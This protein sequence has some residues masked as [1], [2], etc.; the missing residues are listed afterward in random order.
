MLTI[1]GHTDIPEGTT[2]MVTAV[3][4]PYLGGDLTVA[5]DLDD[6]GTF[7]TTLFDAQAIDGAFTQP[8]RV[9]LRDGTTILAEI[10]ETLIVTN[11]PPQILDMQIERPVGVVGTY[12]GGNATFAD[13]PGD[14]VAAAWDWGDG[15]VDSAGI[16]DDRVV[17]ST[18]MYT[19]AGTYTA[20]LTLTDDAG[21]QAQQAI[22]VKVVEPLIVTFTG[23]TTLP[24]GSTATLGYIASR[25]AEVTLEDW[26]GDGDG[27]FETP[28]PTFLLDANQRDGPSSFPV[29]VR[30]VTFEDVAAI[31]TVMI[32][33]TNVPLTVGAVTASGTPSAGQL[34]TYQARISDPGVNDTFTAQW[35]WGDGTTRVGEVVR[36]AQGWFTRSTH[37]YAPG[38]STI[39]VTVTDDDGGT[40]TAQGA[41][42]VAGTL[43]A[44]SPVLECVAP[45]PDG[46]FVAW[47]GYR[48]PNTTPVTLAIGTTNR[49]TPTPTNRGQP[50]VFQPGRQVRVFSVAFPGTNLVW[51]LHGRTSTASR[52]STRCP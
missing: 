19:A 40:G 18:H 45:Q 24:E 16:L 42:T 41:V 8:I 6:D 28:A 48:N 35:T 2:Q 3:V 36:D 14:V 10:A 4:P 21:A 34:I 27:S 37:A 50:T 25:P 22:P 49:F 43:A 17:L 15:V 7:E 32:T 44:V 38:N 5:W 47:F 23:P 30:V 33:V 13:F 11:Q 20:T 52:N 12:L 1:T 51:T 46:T 29:T 31:E 39:G 9:Q 26:D